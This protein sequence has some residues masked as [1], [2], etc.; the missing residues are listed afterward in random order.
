MRRLAL[1]VWAA[2]FCVASIAHAAAPKTVTGKLTLKLTVTVVSTISTSTPI[3][4]NLQATVSGVTST[5][6]VDSVV[7]DDTVTATRS[8]ATAVCELAIPYQWI[9]FGTADMVSLSYSISATNGSADGRTSQVS[10]D[11]IA[12]PKSGATT[13]FSLTGR[14]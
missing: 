13:S 12:V 14:I 3:Q 9:L 2:V 11:A 1:G 4:C 8:G 7:E 10:F 5:G 6:Q